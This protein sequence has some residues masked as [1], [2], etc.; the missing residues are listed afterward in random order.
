MSASSTGEAWRA[1]RPAKDGSIIFRT[2]S[3][4]ATIFRFPRSAP[5]R[6]S[7]GSAAGLQTTVPIPWRGSSRPITSKVLMASRTEPR[8]T[9]SIRTSSRSGGSRSP[10]FSSSAMRRSSRLATSR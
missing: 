3:S 6:G 5:A 8:L 7:A 4:S 9:P 2:S 10:G 1:A